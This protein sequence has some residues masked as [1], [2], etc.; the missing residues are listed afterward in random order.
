MSLWYNANLCKLKFFH[1]LFTLKITWDPSTHSLCDLLSLR[2]KVFTVFDVVC[3]LLQDTALALWIP[4]TVLS[5]FEAGLSV[6]CFV[7]GLGL[8]GLAPCM[9]K[10]IKEQV[11]VEV[12]HIDPRL[13]L[14]CAL[15]CLPDTVF[16]CLMRL[17]E[18]PL[19][20]TFNFLPVWR[21]SWGVFT[22]PAPDYT[23]RKPWCLTEQKEGQVPPDNTAERASL[24]LHWQY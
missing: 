17:K 10:Y 9:R 6:W 11:R 20:L 1:S 19:N 13:K 4:C 8:R 23:T 14:K 15:T 22:Q 16:L 2:K 24:S 21:N 5:G 3:F 12:A 7:V 18:R